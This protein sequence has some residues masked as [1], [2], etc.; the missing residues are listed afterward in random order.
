MFTFKKFALATLASFAPVMALAQIQGQNIGGLFDS[1]I[2]VI[3]DYLIPLAIALAVLYFLWGILKYITSGGDEEAR[4]T[5]INTI[6]YGII[7]L[8]VMVS[9]WGLVNLL[10]G[11]VSLNTSQPNLPVIH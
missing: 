6:I 2:G 9:V 3:N 7:I 8:F 5:A 1:V 10:R 11:S 4:K